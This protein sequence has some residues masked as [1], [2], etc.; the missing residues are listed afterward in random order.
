MSRAEQSRA[1]QSRAE[2]S[3]AE[4]SRA[5]QSRAEQSRAE[6]SRA[7]QSR[8]EQSRA[9]QSRAEQSRAEQSRDIYLMPP[10]LAIKV[11]RRPTSE[12]PKELQRIV[13]ATEQY[14][15]RLSIIRYLLLKPL[16]SSPLPVPLSLLSLAP[17]SASFITLV[18]AASGM[19]RDF[20][21]CS[22][23]SRRG[24]CWSRSWRSRG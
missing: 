22:L 5:E 21:P 2:Q 3:R 23:Y 12:A 20:D 10:S 11:D 13:P 4:Q 14:L 15:S 6:Q 17:I 8:A 24:L 9:E 18:F 16:T 1:E 7:E 19:V